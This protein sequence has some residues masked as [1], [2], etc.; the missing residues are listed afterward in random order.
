MPTTTLMYCKECKEK[1]DTKPMS[2]ICSVCETDNAIES[3]ITT[4]KPGEEFV[5]DEDG[6]WVVKPIEGKKYEHKNDEGTEYG[7]KHDEGG[8]RIKQKKRK[9]KKRKRKGKTKKRR[10][11]SKKRRRKSKKRR[12]KSKKRRSKSKKRRSKSK[13]K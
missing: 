13:K 10:R 7:Y 8:H 3:N 11:K 5:K 4:L 12:S 9:T 1:T 2:T 6:F